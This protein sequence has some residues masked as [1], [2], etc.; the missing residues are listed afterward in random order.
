MAALTF[1]CRIVSRAIPMIL[2]VALDSC[3][4]TS[5]D[6]SSSTRLA[7]TSVPEIVSTYRGYRKLTPTPVWVNP[8]LAMLCIGASKAQVETARVKFGPH[9]HSAISIYMSESAAR[10]FETKTSFPVGA[11]VVKEKKMLGYRDKTGKRTRL[12]ENG[13]GGMVKRASGYDPIHGDWEYFY[14]E[15]PSKIESGRISS[16][17]ACHDGA[18]HSDYVFGTW[19]GAKADPLGALRIIQKP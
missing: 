15:D 6:G 13:V 12:A 14:F 17:V 10:A 16:C 7:E 5:A 9:A 4:K 1:F 8:D 2:C 18:K 11:V 19:S 3:S